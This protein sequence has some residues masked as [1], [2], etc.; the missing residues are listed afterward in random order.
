VDYRSVIRSTESDGAVEIEKV[1]QCE[2]FNR[3]GTANGS[4]SGNANGDGA[5]VEPK[6][7]RGK[8]EHMK[9]VEYGQSKWGD[10]ALAKYLDWTYGPTT[11]AKNTGGEIISIAVHPG[12]TVCCFAETPIDS[13]KGWSR[14]I[15]LPTCSSRHI[16]SNTHRSSSYV[17]DST[18]THAMSHYAATPPLSTSP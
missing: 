6:P 16:S 8:Y 10:L 11:D 4:G 3:H 17:L 1:V 5:R 9:W 7:K 13:T 2:M 12:E 18:H 15:S 14:L